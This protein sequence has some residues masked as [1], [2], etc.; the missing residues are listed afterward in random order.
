[1]LP[2]FARVWRGRLGAAIDFEV[3][4]PPAPSLIDPCVLQRSPGR[5][6]QPHGL[7]IANRFATFRRKRLGLLGPQPAHEPRGHS[8]TFHDQE[9]LH[10]PL[11]SRTPAAAYLVNWATA[12]GN[13][14]PTGFSPGASAPAPGGG[15]G[16]KPAEENQEPQTARAPGSG[17]NRLGI[18][19]L[20]SRAYVLRSGFHNHPL[21]RHF[22][23]ASHRLPL[24]NQDDR[25][26][27]C[28]F[29]IA[30]PHLLIWCWAGHTHLRFAPTPMWVV[31][32]P[33]R[34]KS[35]QWKKNKE[36]MTRSA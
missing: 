30:A 31:S 11:G 33:E 13:D 3:L 9:R 28:N 10:Q 29:S 25:E 6:A 18:T 20:A 8:F 35:W 2:A 1:M 14:L 12:G 23:F 22:F 21:Q 7:K 19:C 32:C 16:A 24:A 5:P 4:Q 27:K 34:E 26:T 36:T 15:R 17:E